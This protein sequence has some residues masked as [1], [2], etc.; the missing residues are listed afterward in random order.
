VDDDRPICVLLLDARLEETAFRR[1]AE[2]LLR[3][4]AVV[5]VE[6]PRLPAGMLVGRVAKRLG[7]RLPGVPRLV[8]SFDAAHRPLARAFAA[9]HGAELWIAG[10]DFDD[11]EDAAAPAFRLNAPIWDRIEALGIA[12]R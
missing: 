3:A 12:V 10:E 4:P 7:R 1:R 2:D 6:P 11:A 5:A 9:L 8:L